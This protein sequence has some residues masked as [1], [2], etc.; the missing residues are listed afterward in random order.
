MDDGGELSKRLGRDWEKVYTE[1]GVSELPWHRE[2][3]DSEFVALLESGELKPRRVL[4]VGCGAGTDAIFLARR[5]CT[6]T[7]LDIS[8]EAIGIA[9]R[10]AAEAGVGVEFIAGDYLETMFEPGTFDLINDRGCFHHME[11]SGRSGFVEKAH[12]EMEGGGR[13]LLRCWS[14]KQDDIGRGP[15][16]I[17]KEEIRAAFSGRF[18]LGDIVDF[19]FGGDGAHGYLCLMRKK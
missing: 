17:S 8:S 4:D 15:F 19:R 13:Y 2:K 11:P 5:G 9:R 14:D 16:S 7:G 12:R 18:E 10:R 1:R 6:V 3:P